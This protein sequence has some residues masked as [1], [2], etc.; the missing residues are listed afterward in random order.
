MLLNLLVSMRLSWRSR[1]PLEN[2]NRYQEG[3]DESYDDIF[4]HSKLFNRP[5]S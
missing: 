3:S 1:A 4:Y 2:G 5:Q